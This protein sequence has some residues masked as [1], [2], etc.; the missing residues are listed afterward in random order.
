MVA[1]HGRAARLRVARA[2]LGLDREELAAKLNVNRAN[3]ARWESGKTPIPPGIWAELDHLY[4]EFDADVEAV[5]ESAEPG[6][7]GR[8]LVRV[9]RGVTLPDNPFPGWTLR[10]VSEAMRRDPSIEPVF[11]EDD[12]RE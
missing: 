10:V 3:Q 5:L 2:Y 8:R 7:D 1:E 12:P 6:P 4:A 11:P 9:W